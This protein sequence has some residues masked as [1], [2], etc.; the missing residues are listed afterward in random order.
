MPMNGPALGGLA[1]GSLLL[2]S[3]IKGKSILATTQ[4]VISG[5]S[6]ATVKKT[7]KIISPIPTDTTSTSTASSGGSPVA[8]TGSNKSILQKTAA[9][10]GWTGAQWTAL[11]TIE[12]QEA[13]YS[14]TVK[15]PSSDALGMAQ[16]LGHG[17]SNTAGSL[18]NE[19]GGYGLSDAQ[20][21]EANSGVAA[22]QSLWM[23][24]Y[25][26][27]VY[28]NPVNAEQFHLAHNYY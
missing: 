13:G 28:G 12:M 3:A 16:A 10:F 25:I 5:Q 7:E 11:D 18:G 8:N 24:N 27:Q 2:Y 21:K 6:P 15:N 17:T 22:M 1:V 26:K 19:Y 23:C 4:A 9:T 20:A 14:T